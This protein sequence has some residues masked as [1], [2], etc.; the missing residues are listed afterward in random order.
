M[1]GGPALSSIVERWALA[2]SIG[3]RGLREVVP[4]TSCRHGHVANHGGRAVQYDARMDSP[5]IGRA[6]WTI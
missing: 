1:S 3:M 4:L 2:W 5:I 6:G